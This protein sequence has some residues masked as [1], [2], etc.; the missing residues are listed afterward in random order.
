MSIFVDQSLGIHQYVG[1]SAG[2]LG[3]MGTGDYTI[4][5]LATMY[6]IGSGTT[7]NTG[8]AS[9]YSGSLTGTLE[10]EVLT[11]TGKFFGASDFTGFGSY[12]NNVW[13]LIGQSKHAGSNLYHWYTWPYAADGS[14]TKTHGDEASGTHGDGSA[15]A[16]VRL[17]DSDNRGNGYIALVAAWKRVLSDADFD[18][19]CGSTAQAFMNLSTGA[20]DALWLCN[21]SNPASIV[22]STGNGANATTVSGGGITGSQP[23]PPSFN[24]NITTTL[25]SPFLWLK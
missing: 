15:I 8:F 23:D 5:T 16:G 24:Y 1:C 19:L 4:V 9:F 25:S 14:G 22:D 2:T 18:A 7:A 3:T 20:P 6:S 13:Y 12:T 10:R 11:D 17:G 21:V